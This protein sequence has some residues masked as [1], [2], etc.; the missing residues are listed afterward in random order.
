M[1][2]RF[3]GLRR[4]R[5]GHIFCPFCGRTNLKNANPKNVSRPFHYAP[6]PPVACGN[7]CAGGALSDQD[8]R[9]YKVIHEAPGHC[10][11]QV[12]EK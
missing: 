8:R 10:M 9:E 7:P 4:P 6:D 5:E 2:S 11:K 3:I 1:R 12:A